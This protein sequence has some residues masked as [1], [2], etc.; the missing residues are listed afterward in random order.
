MKR[1]LFCICTIT[2]HK[3]R[4]LATSNRCSFVVPYESVPFRHERSNNV[5][6]KS[7]VKQTVSS[8]VETYNDAQKLSI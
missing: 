3:A 4:R 8:T 6:M 5:A 7:G 1:I 2:N